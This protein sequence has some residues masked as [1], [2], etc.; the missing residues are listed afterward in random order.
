MVRPDGLRRMPSP[1]L[2]ERRKPSGN[3]IE[4]RVNLPDGLRRSARNDWAPLA[5]GWFPATAAGPG[6]VTALPDVGGS[7]G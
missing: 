3:R 2:A 7:F 5:F 4:N 1:F 6:Y